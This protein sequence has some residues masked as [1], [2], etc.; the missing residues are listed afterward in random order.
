[1]PPAD[2]VQQRAD[3]RVL[4][5]RS[6]AVGGHRYPVG[7]VPLTPADWARSY[8]ADYPALVA[9]KT[10][11]DPRRVLSPGQGIFGPPR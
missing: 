3:N 10:A 8:G 9:A 2:P 4:Y 7:S 6:R 5:D 11:W 1:V